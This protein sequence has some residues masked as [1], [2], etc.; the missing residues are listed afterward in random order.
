MSEDLITRLAKRN[1]KNY[2]LRPYSRREW[3]RE[4]IS[5][6][7]LH[8]QYELVYL[9]DDLPVSAVVSVPTPPVSPSDGT[10]YYDTDDGNFYSR[11]NGD[12]LEF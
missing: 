2:A 11:Y 4:Q 10:L 8:S 6:P 1:P 9:Y 3:M 5:F 7:W 12:W